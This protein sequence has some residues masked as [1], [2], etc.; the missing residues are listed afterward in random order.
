MAQD[1]FGE[2]EDLLSALL[3][4]HVASKPQ[5]HLMTQDKYRLQT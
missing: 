1:P 2:R 3:P 5:I 4:P